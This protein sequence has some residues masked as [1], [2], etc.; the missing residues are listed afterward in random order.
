MEENGGTLGTKQPGAALMLFVA[1]VSL[2]QAKLLFEN[3][4]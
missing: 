3:V 2:L 4:K 1:L